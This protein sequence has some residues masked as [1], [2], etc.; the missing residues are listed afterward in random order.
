V[1]DLAGA[2]AVVEAVDPGFED[3]LEITTGLWFTGAWTLW[4]T[5]TSQQQAVT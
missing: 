2:G 4:N 1:Q 3:P 5:L